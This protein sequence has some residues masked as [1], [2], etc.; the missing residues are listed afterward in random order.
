MQ[1]ALA[2]LV[3][4]AGSWT[5]MRLL[6]NDMENV[7][8]SSVAPFRMAQAQPQGPARLLLLAFA[9]YRCN[10]SPETATPGDHLACNYQHG[11]RSRQRLCGCFCW[12]VHLAGL[13]A[14]HNDGLQSS[15]LRSLCLTNSCAGA[16][17]ATHGN[18]SCCWHHGEPV[19]IPVQILELCLGVLAGPI[20]RDFSSSA[21]SRCS[22]S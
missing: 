16:S 20:E 14:P 4:T 7:S 22:G 15:G 19:D 8:E 1:A 21:G 6:I 9:S 17:S 12:E 13:P 18:Y 10:S 3:G 5:Y 11:A 2:A